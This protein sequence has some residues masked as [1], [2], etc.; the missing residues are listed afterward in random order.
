MTTS[1]SKFYNEIQF[2]GLYNSKEIFKKSHDFFL[3]KFL[4]LD[5]L[6]FK[7]KL[8]EAGCG[9]GYTTHIIGSLRRDVEITGIDFSEKSLEFASNF[10]KTNNFSNICFEK[11]DLR[12]LNL[13]ENY[14]DMIICTGV[15]H[16]IP[17]SK[18]IF[19]ELCRSLKNNGFIIIGLYHPWGRF[20][21]HLRQSFFQ[22]THGKFRWID[23]RIRTEKWTNERKNTWYRDQY[24]H[25]YEEDFSHT[26]LLNWFNDEKIKLIDSI[27]YFTGN[28]LAYN[29][30]MMTKYGS[31]GGLYIF[32]GQKFVIN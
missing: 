11:K 27:P 5:F 32:I 22:I 10:S 26:K 17:K 8:L 28:N 20:S 18:P 30:Y 29:L 19:K 25:P 2:P 24:E 13:Q 3:K 4:D 12:E 31:Q 21:T 1:I 6:P 9:T 16:H 23:P 15:L 14:Y 7:G